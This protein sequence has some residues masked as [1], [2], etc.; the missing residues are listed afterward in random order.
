M[1]I[2][3]IKKK[4]ILLSIIFVTI[5]GCD[6]F[7]EGYINTYHFHGAWDGKA[8]LNGSQIDEEYSFYFSG[9]EKY[10]ICK[11][12]NNKWE[13]EWSGTYKAT[14]SEIHIKGYGKW[15]YSMKNRKFLFLSRTTEQGNWQFDLY[16]EKHN[17]N[18]DSK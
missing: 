16:R 3:N 1:I 17:S 5:L 7:Y 18:C 10:K 6:N 11:K 15:K 14:R 4:I 8:T 12:K 13:L 2:M 9:I